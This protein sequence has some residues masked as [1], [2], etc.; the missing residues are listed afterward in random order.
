MGLRVGL[1]FSYSVVV[2]GALLGQQ[3]VYLIQTIAGSAF[4]GDDGPARSASLAQAEGLA[5]SKSG[6]VYAAYHEWGT[7]NKLGTIKMVRRGLLFDDPNAGTLAPADETAVL[8]ILNLFLS[9]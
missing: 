1:I 6:D 3:P 2:C 9:Q 5:V 4:V 7:K 8:D